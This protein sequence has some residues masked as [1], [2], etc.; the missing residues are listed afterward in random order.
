MILFYLD[1]SGTGLKDTRSPYFVLAAIAVADTEWSALEG[2]VHALKRRLV[3]WAKPEDWEIKGR[4]L[5]RGENFFVNQPW[6]KRAAAFDEIAQMIGDLPCHLFAVQT[7]KRLLPEFVLTDA[8]LYRITFWRLLDEL[9]AHLDRHQQSGMLLVDSRSNIQ[10]RSS[11]QDRRLLDAYREWVGLRAEGSPFVELPWFGF[12]AFYAGLQLADFV[13]Y[14]SDFVY[15]ERELE[16]ENPERSA[17]LHQAL[18]RIER[19][20]QVV[21]I[22]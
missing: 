11:V 13:A 18:T 14:L 15:S 19:K 16:Q 12:S 20:L 22:P 8:D 10:V 3:V 4:E 7:D 2:Q 21:R 9:A 17:P 6:E 5:R 1:E